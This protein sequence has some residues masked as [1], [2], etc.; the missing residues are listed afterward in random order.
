MFKNVLTNDQLKLSPLIRQY[1]N[2]FYLADGTAIALQI[3]HRRSIDFDLFTYKPFDSMKVTRDK[4]R[5]DS[6]LEETTDELTMVVDGVMSNLLSA[7]RV[8]M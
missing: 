3:G 1:A 7:D 2:D 5:T 6:T 8:L 4:H